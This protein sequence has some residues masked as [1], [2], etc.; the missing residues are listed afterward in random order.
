MMNF[1]EIKNAEIK[2]ELIAIYEDKS[3]WNKLI[4]IKGY[5]FIYVS[6]KNEFRI[7]VDSPSKM[8]M[9]LPVGCMAHDYFMWCC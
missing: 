9:A 2:N 7:Q 5:K 1:S 6:A 4:D 8:A 3:K